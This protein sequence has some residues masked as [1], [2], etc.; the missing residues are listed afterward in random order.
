MVLAGAAMI[1]LGACDEAPAPG[2]QAT[3]GAE[4]TPGKWRFEAEIIEMKS[5]KL[6]D[7]QLE[8]MT[9]KP[10]VDERCIAAHETKRLA[11]LFPQQR[12]DCTIEQDEIR[13]G[14]VKGRSQC[15]TQGSLFD[16]R[17]DGSYSATTF[18]ALLNSRESGST[19]P[20]G[21]V[22]ITMRAKGRR[23]GDC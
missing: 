18:E 20:D 2:G 23:I 13:D 16:T 22:R 15:R 21:N 17:I 19:R 11:D 3:P 10:P 8:R 9:N 7:R 1:L 4:M 12:G 6:S 5:D 14:L